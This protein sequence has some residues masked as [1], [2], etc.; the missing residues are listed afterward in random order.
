MAFRSL[1]ASLG[2][3]LPGTFM[4]GGYPGGDEVE[5]SSNVYVIP[6]SGECAIIDTGAGPGVLRSLVR[7]LSQHRLRP[8]W[9][10]LTHDH[11]DHVSNGP[12]LRDRYGAALLIH[13]DDR[14]RLEHRPDGETN[15]GGRAPA[16]NVDGTVGEGDVL[17]LGT[18]KLTILHT[19]GHSPGSICVH[20][21]SHGA[22]FAGDLPLWMGPGRR[23]PLGDFRLWQ[24]SMERIRGLGLDMIGWGHSLPTVGPRACERFLSG[25]LERAEGLEVD[26]VRHLERGAG[27]IP[28]LLDCIINGGDGLHRRLLQGSLDAILHALRDEGR[29]QSVGGEDGVTWRLS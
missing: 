24:R 28:R 7:H 25:T 29:V 17:D 20:V 13:R 14:C 18:L 6:D 10:L 3:Y 9:V 4:D 19:P 1:R 27:T 12:Q 15:G 5:L 2:H 8:R 26:V 21:P 22:L 16:F 11:Y 23:H